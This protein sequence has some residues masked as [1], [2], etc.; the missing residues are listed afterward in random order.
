[1]GASFRCQDHLDNRHPWYAGDVGIG[2]SPALAERVRGADV[3]LA[4][5][6]GLGEM[7]T[8]GY[9]PLTP[10]VPR[11]ALIHVQ[12][13]PSELGRV[14]RPEIAVAARAAA[15]AGQLAAAARR[16]SVDREAWLAA[17]QAD[18]EAWR[19][20][21]VTPGA[22]KRERVV[23]HLA[24]ALPGDAI[25]TNG[26]GNH[27]A[28]LHRDHRDRGVRT[29]LAATSGSMGYGLPAAIAAKLGHPGREVVRLASDGRFQMVVGT[30]PPPAGTARPSSCRSRTTACA[31]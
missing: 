22:L 14:C 25:V 7:T 17:A 24:E 5:G 29:Q 2:L 10:P 26:A 19:E 8:S 15:V 4:L 1:M 16:P 11:Q 13:D 31:A 21:Q 12:P 27:S 23:A 28:W 3:I 6:A 30:S 18:Y 9:T 20:P